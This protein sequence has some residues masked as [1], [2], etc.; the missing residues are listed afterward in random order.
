M[1]V[2]GLLIFLAVFLGW[3]CLFVGLILTVVVVVRNL[4]HIRANNPELTQPSAKTPLMGFRIFAVASRP[5]ALGPAEEPQRRLAFR[6]LRLG[7]ILL[8]GGLLLSFVV[9]M[10]GGAPPGAA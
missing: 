6:V 3:V 5:G 4:S 9:A 7:L 1:D 8:G 10:F 2:F